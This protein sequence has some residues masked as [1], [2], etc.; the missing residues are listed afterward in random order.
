MPLSRQLSLGLFFVLLMVFTGTLMLN[1]SNTKQAIEHQL[2]SHAQD[3]A[4]SLG[5]S[6]SPHIGDSNELP[7]IE[8]MLNA[9][10]DSGYYRSIILQDANGNTL[11]EKHYNASVD[12]VPTWFIQLFTLNPPTAESHINDGWTLAGVVTVQSHPGL[13]YQQ[14]WRNVVDSFIFITCIFT[15]ALALL[16]VLIRWVT[17]PISQVVKHLESMSDHKFDVLQISPKSLELKIF[18]KSFNAMSLRLHDLFARLSEQ[19]ER[20]RQFAYTDN[21]TKVGN[22]RAFDLAF[23]FLLSDAEQQAHGFLL[24]IR[25]S[26]L[27]QVNSKFGFSAGDAYIKAVCD[28]V[29]QQIDKSPGSATLYR[30]N[31]ADFAVILEDADEAQG[32]NLVQTLIN[33]AKAIEKHEYESGVVHIGAGSYAFGENKSAILE[34]VD[35]ALTNA[36]SEEQRWQIVSQLSHVLSNEQWREQISV[37]LTQGSAEFVAQPITSFSDELEYQE[38]FARFRDPKTG[39]DLPMAELFP[40]AIRLDFAQK[41]DELLV[42]SAFEKLKKVTGK[43]GLNLSRLSLLQPEFQFWFKEQI[44]LLGESSRRLILEIPERALIG[45]IESFGVFVAELKTL[46]V[47]ITIERFGAQFASFTQLRK[48]RPHYLKLDGRYIKNIDSEEDNKLFVHSLVN[49]AHGLGIKVIAERVETSHE[50]QTL[51][52]MQVDFVQGYFIA[53]P[54]ALES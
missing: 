27:P 26:S 36:V 48:M 41:L 22:R 40:V 20:Y 23:D 34:R 7:L 8:T 24:L 32:I 37:L 46:G 5:L 54:T 47:Q 53:A 35:S 12:G 44:V 33:A 3:T 49:I 50:A 21:L 29:A 43:V 30:L 9:I 1:F 2:A 6:I 14:M 10:F 19:T 17:V 31:G 4:T 51:K 38:W 42:L 18:V 52:T 13:A 15:L 39:Q 16:L 28:V 11:L 45:D 25:L